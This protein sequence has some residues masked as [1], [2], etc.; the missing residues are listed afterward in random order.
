MVDSG[1]WSNQLYGIDGRKYASRPELIVANWLHYSKIEY[2]SHPKL[3][4]QETSKPYR[5]DFQLPK[6]ANIEVFM[7]S[8]DRVKCRTNLP[9]WSKDYLNN[10]QKKELYYETEGLPF[11]AIEAGIYRQHGYKRYLSHIQQ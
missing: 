2:I 11:I 9:N 3:K 1:K 6:V 8:K 5:G 10:R 4:L 7:F